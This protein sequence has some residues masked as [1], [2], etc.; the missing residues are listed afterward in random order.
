M[1]TVKI[2]FVSLICSL[3]VIGCAQN[4]ESANSKEAIDYA[5]TLETVEEQADYL[6]KEANAFISSE[7][8]EEAIS[9]AKHVLSNVNVEQYKEEAQAI[10]EEAKTKI[11]AMAK[12]K[13]E[14]AKAAVKDKLGNVGQ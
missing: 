14:D 11:E 1:Q 6:I 8:Y 9:T 7:Q 10:I 13:V 2:L 3:V 5:K 4:P 12:A